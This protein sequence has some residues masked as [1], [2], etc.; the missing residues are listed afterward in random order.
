MAKIEREATHIIKVTICDMCKKESREGDIIRKY[1]SG[2]SQQ[3]FMI[4]SIDQE[5]G[6][7]DLHETCRDILYSKFQQGLDS[8]WRIS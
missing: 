7:I 5:D 8:L 6:N 3:G 2:I 4:I 1:H